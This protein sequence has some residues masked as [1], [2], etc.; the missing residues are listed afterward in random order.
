ME[1]STDEAMTRIDHRKLRRF[2]VAS[3]EKFGV[4]KSDAEIAAN[5]LVMADLRGVDTHGVIR[6]S[7]NAWY[8]KWLSEGSMKAKPDIKIIRETP[9]SALLDG[10]R[11]IGMVIGHRAMELAIR[12]AKESGVAMV[13]VRNSRHFG[14]S[15]NYAMQALA[16]DMIGIA[17]TNASRQVVPT[18]G[19][20]ARFG[21]NPMCYAV[22]ADRELP[23]VLD[24]ATTTAAAGKLELAARFGKDVPLGWALN[25]QAEQTTNPR[26]AQAAR[27]LLP[28]G[29]S[30]EGGS[31]KGYGLAILVEILCGVLTGTMTALNADQ[32]PRGHFFGA[33]R[34]DS[35][36]PAGEFKQ[37]MD[38][39]IRELKSTPPIAGQERVYVAGEIEFETAQERAEHGIP[40][41]SSVLKGLREV[42]EQLSLLYDLE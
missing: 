9:S 2:L 39:L 42:S 17:M 30:R 4:P 24:M 36:R 11:G 16:H 8:V 35:F 12:K 33:I 19:R 21:T 14:M 20:E 38:R 40:L 29:G 25:Q 6:F 7:P 23:F 13:G 32:D 1:S 22:P 10:D 26:T 5:A 18:F 31:H 27:R 15:A 3:F 41:H 34:I 28:L 37:D